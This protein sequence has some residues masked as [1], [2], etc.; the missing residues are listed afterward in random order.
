MANR[1]LECNHIDVSALLARCDPDGDDGSVLAHV[2]GCP[3]CQRKLE[4]LAASDEWWLDCQTQLSIS[5]DN[6]LPAEST[7]KQAD[8]TDFCSGLADALKPPSHPEMLGRLGRYDVERML[9]RGGMGVG[10]KAFDT[11]L[12]RPVAIK[13]LAPHLAGSG[14]ARQRFG[15]EARAAAAVAHEHVVSIH[16]VEV[17]ATH[18]YLVMQYLPG[19]SL[20]SYVES[21]GPRDACDLVRIAHQIAAGLSAA[22]AQGLVHRDIKPG[23]IMLENGLGRVVIT[24]FGLARA[25]DDASLTHSGIVAGTPYYMAPEQARGEQA[26]ARTDLFSLG[27]VMYF[28]ATGHPPFRA[29]QAMAVL[30]RICND[31]QRP[32]YQLNP[33]LPDELI[34]VIDRLLEKKPIRRFGSASEI[35]QVLARI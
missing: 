22:H 8:F 6:K 1:S 12:N 15:R 3:V 28:M 5:N 34:S 9:G 30:H 14:A 31:K 19:E 13:V 7:D 26:D 10:F 33:G 32:L 25:A 2:G 23:N 18:P 21:H 27:A 20:Q 29:E 17:S 35:Q 16:D 11:E 24:D 4:L